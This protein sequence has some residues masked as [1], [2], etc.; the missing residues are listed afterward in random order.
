MVKKD[1]ENTEQSEMAKTLMENQWN[2]DD[3][4][5]IDKRD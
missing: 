2:R 4:G 1:K 5:I 3:G